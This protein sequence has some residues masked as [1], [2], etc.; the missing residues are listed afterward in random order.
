MAQ[1][2]LERGLMKKPRKALI[3]SFWGR[4]I[5]IS[6]QLLQWYLKHGVQVTKIHQCLEFK[7]KRCL[8]RFMLEIADHRRKA[9]EN[10]AYKPIAD[11][12]KLAGNSGYGKPVTDKTKHKETKVKRDDAVGSL[13]KDK[14]FNKMEEVGDIAYEVCMD[15]SKIVQDLPITVGFE[16]YQTSKLRMLEFVYDFLCKYLEPGSFEIIT[17]DTDSICAAYSSDD[18]DSLVRADMREEYFK[19]GK[20]QFLVTS[21][22]GERQPGLFKVEAS[23]TSAVAL[24]S[25]TYFLEDEDENGQNKASH[26]GLSKTN[27]FTIH[28]LMEVLTTKQTGSGI[29]HE[30]RTK[31]DEIYQYEQQRAGL[32]YLY[33]KRIVEDDGIKTRA[34]DN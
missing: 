31:G 24:T 8:E 22:F 26:K 9:D 30:L 11:Q 25:K 16:V 3:N 27:Q 15:K 6:S 13:L 28:D 4:R 29:N 20:A 5:L 2:A 32:A 21:K 34:L 10:A 17:S 12:W 1:F 14:R 18:L 33:P 19:T 7:P 23:A